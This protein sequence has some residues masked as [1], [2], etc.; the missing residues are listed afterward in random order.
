MATNQ[1]WDDSNWREEFK[2]YTSDPKHLELLDNG[3]KK[4]TDSWLLQA[5]HNNWMKLKGYKYPEQPDCSSS[6]QEFNEKYK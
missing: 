5:L 4:L 2:E 6:F 1:D 3:P